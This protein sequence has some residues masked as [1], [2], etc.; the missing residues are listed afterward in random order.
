MQMNRQVRQ[1]DSGNKEQWQ[2]E[3]QRTLA[4]REVKKQ[5]LNS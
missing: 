1:K 2:A 3:K 4:G 5:E